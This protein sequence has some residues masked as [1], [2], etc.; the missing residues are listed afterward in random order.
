MKR[1]VAMILRT[2]ALS[3]SLCLLCFALAGCDKPGSGPVLPALVRGDGTRDLLTEAVSLSGY[4]ES[5]LSGLT[6]YGYG[7]GK[8]DDYLNIQANPLTAADYVL[9]AQKAARGISV[10]GQGVAGFYQYILEETGFRYEMPNGYAV[11]TGF[12]KALEAVYAAA[13][14]ECP[15]TVAEMAGA[16]SQT[17]QKPLARWLSAAAAAYALVAEQAEALTE[18]DFTAL[19]AFTYTHCATTE[20]AALEQMRSLA[21]DISEEAMQQAGAILTEATAQLAMALADVQTLTKTDTVTV[22]PTPLGDVV[23]GS[24]GDDT[25]TSPK[26][27]LILD[28]AGNDTYTG[29]V[30]A[31]SSLRQCL[32]VAVDLAGDDTYNAGNKPSQGCGILGVGLLFDLQGSDTY[33]AKRLAQGCSIIGTGLLYDGQGNDSYTCAVTGQASGFYGTAMLLDATGDDTYDG[34]GFVQASAGNRCVAYLVDGAGNDRYT[35]PEDM[36]AGYSLLDYGG[37]HAGKNGG[38]SQGC[39]WGQ[40]NIADNGLAGGIAGMVDLSGDDRYDGGLWVQGTGYWSGIGFVYNEGGNDRYNAYYYAQASVAH[41]GAGMLLD[42]VGDDTYRLSRGAGLAF[43]W[44]RGVA[45]LADDSGDDGYSCA[46]SYG[47]VANSAY[48]E[49]GIEDQDL[50]CALFLD[51]Q[52]ADRYAGAQRPDA[53]GYGRGGY[54][55]DAGGKDLYF[56]MYSSKLRNNAT[57]CALAFQRGGVFIDATQDGTEIPYFAFWEA[58]KEAAGFGRKQ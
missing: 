15:A 25:Y 54:F 48:D 42:T 11:Y 20:T 47:G 1:I 5:G 13:G 56:S 57:A 34:Y 7:E 35:T 53:H 16:V 19:A 3:L 26:A 33:R 38:F 32:S 40:R 39:G 27:L 31:G 36:P 55:L 45:M 50:T 44:D 18:D 17:A 43:V 6:A 2:V 24:S 58:A 51:A 46:G 28:P 21:S 9:A 29:R 49:K 23:L 14:E 22:I 52:G 10:G 30:A 8:F 37:D 41:Y 4:A 12:G